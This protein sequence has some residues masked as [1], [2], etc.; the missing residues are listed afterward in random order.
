MLKHNRIF[1]RLGFDDF[2]FSSEGRVVLSVRSNFVYGA[3]VTPS[4]VEQRAYC[5]F[6][7]AVL[8]RYMIEV[9]ELDGGEGDVPFIKDNA[10]FDLRSVE[11]FT[12]SNYLTYIYAMIKVLEREFDVNCTDI[13]ESLTMN[14][15]KE[16]A[17]SFISFVGAEPRVSVIQGVDT[18]KYEL[19]GEHSEDRIAVRDNETGLRG[20][21]DFNYKV[22]VDSL[23]DEV[24]DFAEGVS[25]CVLGGRYGAID[26]LGKTVL[27]FDYE[28]VEWCCDTARFLISDKGKNLIK[29]R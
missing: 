29:Y 6:L 23:Y 12:S 5:N 2:L 25:V 14:S 9:K 28:F 8:L 18:R 16:V 20:F 22:I 1:D 15:S 4:S 11:Y 24:S 10:K 7:T 26:R 27:P 19:I 17:R 13:T 3:T 21:V